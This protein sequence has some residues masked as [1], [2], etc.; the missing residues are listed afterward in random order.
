M[1][2]RGLSAAC[3]SGVL[4]LET[5]IEKLSETEDTAKWAE[6]LPIIYEAPGSVS[7]TI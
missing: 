2:R 5:C 4:R 7:N 3:L 1:S 6:C